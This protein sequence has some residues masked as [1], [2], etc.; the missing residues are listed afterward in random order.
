MNILVM[1]WFSMK[2]STRLGSNSRAITPRAPLYTPRLPQPVPPMWNTGMATRET[3]SL[4]Q[5]FHWMSVAPGAR[6]GPSSARCESMAPLGWP[7]V[8]EV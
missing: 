3:S 1:R 4:V 2:S 7:V 5:R 8:P 6:R